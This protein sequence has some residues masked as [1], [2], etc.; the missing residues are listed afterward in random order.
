MAAIT[1]TREIAEAYDATS[2]EMFTDAVLGPTLDC[3]ESLAAG[4]AALEF[5]V[6]TGRVALPLAARGVPVQGIE[7]SEAM[8]EQLRRK[9]GGEA[10]PVTLGDMAHTRVD[11]RFRLVYLVYNTLMNLT[12]QAEQVA[13]FANAAAHLEPGGAFLLEVIVPGIGRVAPGEL[14]RVFT[15]EADHI[16]TETFD[17]PL[18][19][20]SWSH[21][22][23]R[24]DGRLVQHAAPYRYVWPSEL[25][26]MAQLAG[27]R[28]RA[29]WSDW[30]GSPFTAASTNQLVIY[31]RP[32]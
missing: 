11:G 30:A 5:A 3:L 25:D 6:G 31:E 18:G 13:V 32:A 22:W 21:H 23:M 4:G 1:W 26:L 29:R 14:G 10:L 15:L 24:V 27:L 12:T 19:Q 17:D 2:A 16:G 28:L 8:L 9:A 20:I 7:L